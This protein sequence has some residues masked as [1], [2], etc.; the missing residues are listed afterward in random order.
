MSGDGHDGPALTEDALLGGRLRL[1]QPAGGARVAIDTLL[2]AA[3]VAARPGEHLIEA[4]SGSGGAALALARRC[5]EVRVTGVELDPEMVAM[6]SANAALNGLEERV[7]FIEGCV[8]ARP[9]ALGRGRFDQ[10]LVNPPYGDR[11]CGPAPPDG[12]R[13]RAFV[14]D[15]AALRDWIDFCL[16]MIRERG[17][18]TLIHRAD[19]LDTIIAALHGRAGDIALCPL[20]PKAGMAAKRILLRARKGARGGA[21]VLPGLILHDRQGGF[22]PETEHILR[23]AGAL[24]LAPD[25]GRRT[26]SP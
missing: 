3:A 5:A 4:G 18:L 12:G 16:D 13:A 6:A 22:T 21:R 20:W 7:R 15:K 10:A 19:R 24:D 25:V 1:R 26:R 23:D 17:T 2:L 14:T 9:L 11:D 8:T